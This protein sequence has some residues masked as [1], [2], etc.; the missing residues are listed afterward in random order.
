MM[1]QHTDSVSKKIL[2]ANSKTKNK[3]FRSKNS[4]F[5]WLIEQGTYSLSKA[6]KDGYWIA[7]QAKTQNEC[8]QLP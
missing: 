4:T 5:V 6:F 2:D 3:F 1:K 7:K 8:I